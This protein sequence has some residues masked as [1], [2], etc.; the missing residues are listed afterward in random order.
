MGIWCRKPIQNR[1]ITAP[2]T[3]TTAA[4]NQATAASNALMFQCS[5]ERSRVAISRT[6]C[7]GNKT[8]LDQTQLLRSDQTGSV[9]D[10]TSTSIP[11]ATA[12]V[13]ASAADSDAVK[14]GAIA[15]TRASTSLRG[16]P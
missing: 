14:I 13:R 9:D 10:T 11:F 8:G 12:R 6:C 4:P 16:A 1:A 7:D 2:T 5:G 3:S 15:A